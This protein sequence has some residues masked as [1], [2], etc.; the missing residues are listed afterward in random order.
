MLEIE[1]APMPDNEKVDISDLISDPWVLVDGDQDI[2]ECDYNSEKTDLF[3]LVY[4]S[5]L[6]VDD[7]TFCR[8]HIPGN[9]SWIYF[10]D[11]YLI[12]GMIT[13]A[14][15]GEPSDETAI[16]MYLRIAGQT[17]ERLPEEIICE[18][19][20][21]ADKS[22][23]KRWSQIGYYRDFPDE[24]ESDFASCDYVASAAI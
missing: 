10:L 9:R 6:S 19:A 17:C 5:A 22:W 16:L 2:E 12:T 15:L 1:W 23:L 7:F 24:L 14:G 13:I 21:K 18:N 4:T 3:T 20:F 11:S 8:A